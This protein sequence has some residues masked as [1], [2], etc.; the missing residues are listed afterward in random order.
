[1]SDVL[2]IL[3]ALQADKAI[4]GFDSLIDKFTGD[5]RIA[6]IGKA[7]TAGVTVP[8]VGAL[9]YA[10]GEAVK[11]NSAISN[12]VRSLDLTTEETKSFSAEVLKLAPSLGLLPEEFANVAA[13]AGKMGVAKDEVAK[14]GATL[15]ELATIAD[16]PIEQ[17]VKLGGSIKTI[18]RQST[19]EFN[20]FGAAVNALDDKIGG[21]TPNILDFVGNIG[22]IGKSIGFNAQEVAAFGATFEKLGF[23]SAEAGTAFK[24]MVNGLFTISAASEP[25]K[26]AFESLGFSA[27][28]FGKEMEADPKAALTRFLDTL[29]A[30]QSESEKSALLVKIFGNEGIAA[31]SAL[32][33]STDILQQAFEVAGD[34]TAN[35]DKKMRE[36]AGKMTDP[37]IQ[38][39]VLAAQMNALSIQFGQVLIPILAQLLSTIT[40][41]LAK[42]GEF[43]T[44]NPEFAKFFVIAAT[45]AAV[46]APALV[47]ISA[48]IGAITSIGGIITTVVASI[49]SAIALIS[50]LG[51][52]LSTLGLM[53][54]SIIPIIIAFVTSVGGIV[55][56]VAIVGAA[57]IGLIFNV[58][59]MRDKVVQ[60]FTS[61]VEGIKYL[62]SDF[63][64]SWRNGNNDIQKAFKIVWDN[65]PGIIWDSLMVIGQMVASGFTTVVSTIGNILWNL[66]GLIIS[67]FS[68]IISSVSSFHATLANALINAIESA[69]NAGVSVFESFTASFY[70]AGVGLINSFVSG[71]TASAQNA[72][73]AVAG[74]MSNVRQ[75]LPFSPAKLGALSDLDKSGEA[76]LH[77]FA[78]NFDIP[79]LVSKFNQGLSALDPTLSTTPTLTPATAT[80]QGSNQIVINFEQVLNIDTKVTSSDVINAIKSS[81]R[82][83]LKVLEQAQTYI[84]RRQS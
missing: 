63:V 37:A 48:L 25:A 22:A 50:S 33:G 24:N 80:N 6:G 49:G 58:G 39:K 73:S 65:L 1:M 3:V 77:T 45:G 13:E 46:I 18:F 8:I 43:L 66:P 74:V 53:F 60:I 11:F 5:S 30:V 7:F 21:T 70:N 23:Q 44:L 57:I 56:I 82:E 4:S 64:I 55:T 19:E 32:T 34:E 47:A 16:T 75:Y 15:A 81:Q 20:V 17:F 71:I 78:D 79:Y 29:N 2:N 26:E 9:G 12:T 27:T 84:N 69:I 42:F 68:A 41:V 14:F 59:G 72:Y 83:F 36:F 35:L 61:M 40:P 28:E 10:T 67:V 76:F 51:G 52:V 62:I 38:S 54:G 31:I